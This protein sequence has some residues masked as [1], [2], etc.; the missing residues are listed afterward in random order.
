MI[1]IIKTESEKMIEAWND[2]KQVI[3]LLILIGLAWWAQTCIDITI[4][5][6]KSLPMSI[7]VFCALFFIFP[8]L[9]ITGALDE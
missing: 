8:I 1:E 3:L 9:Y 6:K 7:V 2:P 5:G 4:E